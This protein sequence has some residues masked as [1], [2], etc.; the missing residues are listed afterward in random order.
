MEAADRVAVW[1]VVPGLFRLETTWAGRGLAVHLCAGEHALLVDSGFPSTAATGIIPALRELNLAP[2]RLRWLVVTHA[3]ADHLG[4]NAAI[5]RW[6]PQVMVLAHELDADAVENHACYVAQHVDALRQTGFDVAQLDVCDPGFL[7]LQGP[8]VPVAMRVHGEE[9]LQLG[10]GR[11]VRLLHAPGHTAGHLMVFVESDG[12]L[13][14]GDAVLG[15]G[16]PDVT[17]QLIMPPHYFDVAWYLTT[18]KHVASLKPETV[19]LT[20]YPVMRGRQVEDFLSRS[21][22]FVERCTELLGDILRTTA[23]PMSSNEIVASVRSRIGIPG[24][25]Y[26]Y[27]LLTRAHLHWFTERDLVERTATPSG[28]RWRWEG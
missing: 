10:D 3:S 13:I 21:A 9:V 1:E 16:V 24:A 27:A 18:I 4:G 11:E 23:W 20:H 7:A 25:D 28:D 5:Q 2:E 22:S 12:S 15:D 6:A 19:L 8:E 17:G 14:A 26:Q